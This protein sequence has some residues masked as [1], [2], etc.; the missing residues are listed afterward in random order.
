VAHAFQGAERLGYRGELEVGAEALD[1]LLALGLEACA[2]QFQALAGSAGTGSGPRS[3]STGSGSALPVR[4]CSP[5]RRAISSSCSSSTG[6]KLTTARAAGFP[7]R[8][9]A[10]SV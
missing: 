6:V 8:C 3:A 5:T 1:H 7:S 9:A 10:M 4:R 2:Q